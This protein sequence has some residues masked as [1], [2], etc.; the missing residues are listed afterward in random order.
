MSHEHQ[1]PSAKFKRPTA[2]QVEARSAASSVSAS[3]SASTSASGG[4]R[5]LSPQHVLQLQKAAGNR[6]VVQMMHS[7]RSSVLQRSAEGDDE[8]REKGR[9][10]SSVQVKMEAALQSNMS[11][12]RVHEDSSS[13]REVGALAYTQGSDV[14][15]APGQYQP[16]TQEGQEL[17]GHELQHVVQQ[18]K[19]RIEPTMS[20]AGMPV[21]DDPALE[22]EADAMGKKAASQKVD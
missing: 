6:A 18:R 7:S 17:I 2:H 22:Q 1:S 14:H 11:D 21:N 16:D 9:L 10:P 19:G 4:E 5:V 3:A 15:F 13:A 8:Q 20:V 12:V